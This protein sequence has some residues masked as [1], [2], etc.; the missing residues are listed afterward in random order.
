MIDAQR[1][2][3]VIRDCR[4]TLQSIQS[5]EFWKFQT[6]EGLHKQKGRCNVNTILHLLRRLRCKDSNLLSQ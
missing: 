3:V 6:L 5:F 2:Q 1:G 4:S